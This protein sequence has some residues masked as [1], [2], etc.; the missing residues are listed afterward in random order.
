MQIS[1]IMG[2]QMPHVYGLASACAHYMMN[3]KN[4]YE[5]L[6]TVTIEVMAAGN[7]GVG[8]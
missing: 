5:K 7:Q 8:Q 3:L 4:S 6:P 2:T 1:K